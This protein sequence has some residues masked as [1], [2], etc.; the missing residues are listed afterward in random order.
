M[1]RQGWV[2]AVMGVAF[3]LGVLALLYGWIFDS[4]SWM[5]L[6]VIAIGVAQ[7]IWWIDSRRRAAS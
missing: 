3:V 5:A 1:D 6:G 4:T 2:T 7:L